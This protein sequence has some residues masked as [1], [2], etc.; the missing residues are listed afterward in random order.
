MNGGEKSIMKETL[1]KSW[2]K[3]PVYCIVVSWITFW[4]KLRVASRFVILKLPDG[5]ASIDETRLLIISGIMFFAALAS[6]GVIFFRRMKK[7]EIFCSASVLVLFN[8]VAGLIV[9]FFQQT[10]FGDSF[11]FFYSAINE[12]SE[13]VLLQLI[14]AIGLNPWIG[15]IV[16]WVAPYLFVLFGKKSI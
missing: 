8:F 13:F 15:V 1:K 6:G 10:S 9:H 16:V 7:Q 5:T 3:V 2:W 11:S 14:H 4:L 12:W